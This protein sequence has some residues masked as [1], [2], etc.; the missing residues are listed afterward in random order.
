MPVKS[1]RMLWAFDGFR[2]DHSEHEEKSWTI[3]Y[4]IVCLKELSVIGAR[5]DSV[6]IV[7]SNLV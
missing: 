2:Q 5:E 6:T 3:H 1:F 4:A 7:A